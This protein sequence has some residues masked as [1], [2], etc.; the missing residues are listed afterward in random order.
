[1]SRHLA[2]M[3][4]SSFGNPFEWQN[5]SYTDTAKRIAVRVA[6]RIPASI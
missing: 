6:E 2:G 3:E 1:M 5:G 4:D